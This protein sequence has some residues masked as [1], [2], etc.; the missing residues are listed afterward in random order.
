MLH[1]IG[2]IQGANPYTRKTDAH[3]I[4]ESPWLNAINLEL[5][6]ARLLDPLIEGFKV[7]EFSRKILISSSVVLVKFTLILH[8]I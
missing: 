4:T 1:V 8:M 2:L 3:V 7:T 6:I 5:N